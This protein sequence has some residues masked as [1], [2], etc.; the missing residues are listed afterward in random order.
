MFINEERE[1]R[2]DMIF[3][4]KIVIVE[5]P[6]SIGEFNILVGAWIRQKRQYS[7]FDFECGAYAN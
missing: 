2:F 1:T 3:Y 7:L 6:I 4:K 5:R